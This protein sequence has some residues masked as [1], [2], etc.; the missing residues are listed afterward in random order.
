MSVAQLLARVNTGGAALSQRS[1]YNGLRDLLA[2]D[3]GLER[4]GWVGTR[5]GEATLAAR[6]SGVLADGAGGAQPVPRAGTVATAQRCPMPVG[7]QIGP[8][9]HASISTTA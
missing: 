7:E 4:T 2:G 8:T 6:R 5:S 3:T 9:P 1:V